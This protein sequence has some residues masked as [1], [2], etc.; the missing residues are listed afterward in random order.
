V[1][2]DTT[3][4]VIYLRGVAQNPLRKWPGLQPVVRDAADRLKQLGA[5]NERVVGENHNLCAERD[6]L[7]AIVTDLAKATSDPEFYALRRRAC[8]ATT[9]QEPD[10]G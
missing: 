8:E 4:L 2:D 10:H 9:G 6:E 1:S 5:Q 3:E 7:R